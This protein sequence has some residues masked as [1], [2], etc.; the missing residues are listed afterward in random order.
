MTDEDL[1]ARMETAFMD[2]SMVAVSTAREFAL[3]LSEDDAFNRLFQGFMGIGLIVGVASIG[4]LSFR[5][6]EQRRQSIGMLRAIGF[7]S[8]QVVIQFLLEATIVTLIGTVLGL[9]LGA[10]TSWNI[11]NELAKE[12][13]GLRYAIPWVNILIIVGVAWFFSIIMTVLP[14]RRAGSI[15]PAEAL[16]YE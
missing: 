6:V 1:A 12:T 10:I 13:D 8:R 5:A 4:V 16:R 9:V 15:Y 14:A 3:S 11:F 2:R 7:R